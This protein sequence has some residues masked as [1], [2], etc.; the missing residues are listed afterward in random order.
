MV[1]VAR[2]LV[3]SVVFCRLLFV[4]TLV[5]L[6][7]AIVLSIRPPCKTSDYFFAIFEPFLKEIYHVLGNIKL[8]LQLSSRD[9]YTITL[10]SLY[11]KKHL[12]FVFLNL[13]VL[14]LTL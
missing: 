6:F 12:Y 5:V 4:F 11:H 14:H 3:F 10:F 8:G 9:F 13:N 7:M 2:S 1:R